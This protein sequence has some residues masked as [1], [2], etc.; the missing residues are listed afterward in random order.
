MPAHPSR[1]N[2]KVAVDA[3]IFTVRGG[4]LQTL[5]IQMK[6]RPFTG[7]W[8]FPGGLLGD[9]QTGVEAARRILRDQTGVA[10]AYLEQLATFDDPGRDPLGRVVSLAYFA[11]IPDAGAALRTT[12][13]YADVRWWPAGR[14][15]ALAYDHRRIAAAALRRLRAKLGYT[16]IAWSM[17]PPEF[18]FSQ[19]QRIYEAILG[20]SLDKR[21]FRKKLLSLELI[22]PTGKMSRGGSHRPA[23]LY[24]FRDRKPTFVDII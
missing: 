16:N 19:L 4:E 10:P 14:L 17:L 5:L 2:I 11:L 6:K 8:A 22:R 9:R 13:K 23:E 18:A 7:R 15:P 20:R 21:N 1:Q 3:V 12:A 24:R